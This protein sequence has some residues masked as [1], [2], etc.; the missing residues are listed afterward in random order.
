MIGYRDD[1]GNWV[2][3]YGETSSVLKV[4]KTFEDRLT[5]EDRKFLAERSISV[6]GPNGVQ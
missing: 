4:P 1:N 5:P 6:E 3:L 2:N